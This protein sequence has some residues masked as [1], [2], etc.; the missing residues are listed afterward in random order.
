MIKKLLIVGLIV[1]I[2]TALL[3]VVVGFFW[4][5]KNIS[6][7][8]LVSQKVAI[9]IKENQTTQSVLAEL[10]SKQII[11][12]QTAARIY[13]RL[14]AAPSIRPGNYLVSADQSLPQILTTLSTQPKDI[15]LTFPEGWRKEQFASRLE[16]SYATLTN[17]RFIMSEFLAN[18]QTKEGQLFPD[19][20][21][22]PADATAEQIVNILTNN[23]IKKTG[24]TMSGPED[25]KILIIASLIERESRNAS[26]RPIISGIIQNRLNQG[27]LL[28]IDATIQYARDSVGKVEK[29]WLPVTDTTFPSAYNTYIHLGLPPGPIASPGLDAIEAAR[30]PE[31]T[32]YMFYLHDAQGEVHYAKTLPQH[33]LNVDKYL[34]P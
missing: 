19:T 5:Q 23:F 1:I 2:L 8:S 32:D 27:W 17:S 11:R 15:R 26:E 28:N 9:S 6:P 29:Y 21:L 25:E 13:L 14:H 31:A 30:H 20:Y 22:L 4:Y 10:E 18:V 12:S 24:L 3:T 7:R 16:Q 34:K 33:N